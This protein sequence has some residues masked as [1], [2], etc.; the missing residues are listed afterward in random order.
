LSARRDAD[1]SAK[2]ITDLTVPSLFILSHIFFAMEAVL[3]DPGA[4]QKLLRGQTTKS[5]DHM[6]H[7]KIIDATTTV[8][9]P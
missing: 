3:F 8:I 1:I 7:Q 2:S 4:M 5:P 9:I 6:L